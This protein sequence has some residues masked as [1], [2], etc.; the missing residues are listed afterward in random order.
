MK[1]RLGRQRPNRA[2]LRDLA[3]HNPEKAEEYL[4]AHHSEWAELATQTPHDAADILEAIDEEGAADLLADLETLTAA[5]EVLDE[6]RPEAAADVIEE[7]A[8]KD[9]ARLIEE[10]ETDQAADLLGALESQQRDAVLEALAD[11]ATAE[12]LELLAYPPDSAGGMMT[13]EFASLPEGVTAGEAVEALRRLHDQLG[14]NLS[15]V[16]VVDDA[17]RLRGVVS[18]RDLFFARPGASLDDVM[19]T[20]PVSV[21]A[22]TDRE[23]VSE[24][25][26]RYRLHALPVVDNVGTLI[27]MVR[28]GEAMEA[29]AAEA[30]EDIAVSFGAGAEETVFTPIPVSIQRRLPW[31]VVN[32]IIGLGI[33][34]AIDPFRETIEEVTV[35]AA[36]MP[37]VALLGGNSG[38][39]SLAVVIRAMALGDLPQGRA[40]RAIRR[41]F[42]VGA[43]NGVIISILAAIGGA[44]VAQDPVVG[45]VIF[46]AV[47]ANQLIAGV[48]GSG[49]PV[50]L[51]RL[52]LDPA[53]ASNIFLTMVTD[54]V[55]F[56]GFLLT[57]S[58][59]L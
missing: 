32:L 40:G 23:I 52:G 1:F 39:Q 33:A 2:N 48:A 16:Y 12:V 11:E 21:T 47:L 36:L 25:V 5:A 26:Q 14:S 10:M 7:L 38:A 34:L 24:L 35:L 51:R 57:A 43:V 22:T 18:F 17:K 56:G 3:E 31:I 59:L 41:E 4:D 8:P 19:I 58:I 53:L 15:Y 27:G 6:M 46:V 50:L 9:A 37:M 44:L 55:G 28:F 13:T 20:E 45:V 29:A 54:L 49:I 42:L 30:T